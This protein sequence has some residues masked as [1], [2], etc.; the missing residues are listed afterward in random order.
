MENKSWIEMILRF[1][2]L[3]M[4]W[5]AL[6]IAGLI[7]LVPRQQT[8]GPKWLWFGVVILFSIIGP[9]AYFLFGREEA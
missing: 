8:R 9:V 3:L 2:P 4:V 5:L 7:D 6:L 1:A